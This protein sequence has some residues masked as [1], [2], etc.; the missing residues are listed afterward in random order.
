MLTECSSFMPNDCLLLI[1]NAFVLSYYL[2]CTELWGNACTTFL[3]PFRILQKKCIRSICDAS[4]IEYCETLVENLKL[5]MF[6]DLL[7]VSIITLM[8]KYFNNITASCLSLSRIMHT[9]HTRYSSYNFLFTPFKLIFVKDL[10]YT[11][12]LFCRITL[13]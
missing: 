7:Y 3:Q 5:L 11:V 9:F 13:L 1:Y 12:L 8:Y 4:P 10:Y 6:D 2:Y